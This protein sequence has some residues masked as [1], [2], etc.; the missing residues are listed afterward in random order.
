MESNCITEII[1][2]TCPDS[3]VTPIEY[4]RAVSIAAIAAPDIRGIRVPYENIPT[5]QD[6]ANYSEE[7]N[8]AMKI[9]PLLADFGA[10]GVG[11]FTGTPDERITNLVGSDKLKAS[12]EHRPSSEL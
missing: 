6:K 10:T 12:S 4:L 5:I 2:D 1:V 9:L 8:P 7:N 3:F 11:F